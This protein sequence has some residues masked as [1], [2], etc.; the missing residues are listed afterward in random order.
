MPRLRR[1][2][3]E[4]GG[5]F[6]DLGTFVPH[7]IGAIAVAGLAPAGVLFGFGAFLVASGL[8]YGIPIAVQPMKAISALVLTGD[9]DAGQIAATGLVLGLVLL[10]LGLTGTIGRLAR[11]IPQSVSAGLQL[12]LG[13]SMVLLGARLM[14]DS[15]LLGISALLVLLALSRSSRL[16]AAPV[17]VAAALALAG[18]NGMAGLPAM[19]LEWTWP[20]SVPLALSDFV[21]AIERGLVAQLPLTLTNAVILTAALARE[22]FPERSGR[23]TERNLALSTGFANIALAP[24]GAMPM[25][26]GAGGLQAQYRFGARTGLAPVLFGA[27]LL[28]AAFLFADGAVALF[29]AIPLA[30]IGALLAVAGA[31]LAFSRRLLDARA[32]CR[33][34]IAAAAIGTLAFDPA[35]GLVSGWT[36]EIVRTALR[37]R[38]RAPAPAAGDRDTPP[39]RK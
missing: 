10:V 24:F 22:L 28:S 18:W 6:G 15:P 19:P 29:A 5:A 23:A 8:F 21:A 38:G 12:G 39:E 14:L 16:P 32:E 26:H 37:G 34:A 36:V 11:F 33:P 2:L 35:V 20:A 25:C 7:V 31:D 1:F 17:V 30:A 9:L 13:L 27:M 3:S 4:L